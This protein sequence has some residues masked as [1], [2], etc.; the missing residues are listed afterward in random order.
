MHIFSL[1]LSLCLSLLDLSGIKSKDG[2]EGVGKGGLKEYYEIHTEREGWLKRALWNAERE[3][4][5]AMWPPL[6]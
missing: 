1:S 2:G 5:Q 6:G 4:G 3:G